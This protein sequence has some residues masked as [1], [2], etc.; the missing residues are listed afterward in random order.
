MATRTPPVDPRIPRGW[1]AASAGDLG[2]AQALFDA[3]LRDAPADAAALTGLGCVWRQRGQLSTAIRHCDAAIRAAPTYAA[4]WLERG[5]VLATGGSSDAAAACFARASDLDPH[6]VAA[7]VGFAA[8]AARKGEGAAATDYARRALAIDPANIVAHT[9][10]ATVALEAGDAQGAAV[11]LADALGPDGA[12]S[13]ARATAFA[14]LG[15]A[16]EALGRSNDAYAAYAH[17]K[18]IIAAVYG[19]R[20]EGQPSHTEF[21]D[22]L[23]GA[24]NASGPQNWPAATGQTGPAARHIFL[25]GYPRS[26]T[27]LVENILAS[28][29][30]TVAIEERPTL[31]DADN[32]YLGDPNGMARLASATDAE[33]E[34]LRTAYW[35]KVRLAGG[36]CVGKTLIDMD[37]LKSIRL[38]L[39][40]RLFPHAKTIVMR[41]DPRDV[42][43]SCFKTLL[44]PTASSFE[45]RSLETT[46]RHYDAVVRLTQHCLDTLPIDAFEL[47]Y[48]R[49]VGSFDET[50][51][52][53]CGFLGLEW[54]PELRHFDRTA[55]ARGVTTASAAQV[56][57]PLYDGGRQW[58][59]YRTQLEPVLPIL[60]PWIERL[61]F[62][63]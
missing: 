40:A 16:H 52:D 14:L 1:H 61:G 20:F 7:L 23:T 17:A 30:D 33:L 18:T 11:R 32:T 21:V 59:R 63:A 15:D 2:S 5:F 37:P 8:I 51:R 54:S 3:A 58:E 57:K 35:D 25:L 39:I 44:S 46:A 62:A 43:W 42:V 9:A 38:P 56:R 55:K 24:F 26:G 53:L 47:R 60:A 10:L 4:A 36:D 12:P 13:D 27:T 22:R 31:R 6:N 50:T 45:Y 29:P 49:L 34:P 19:A 28:L 41:R 48:D